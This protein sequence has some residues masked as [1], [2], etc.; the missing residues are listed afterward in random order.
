MSI[1]LYNSDI[2]RIHIILFAFVS[3]KLGNQNH[4]VTISRRLFLFI[5]Q[6]VCLFVCLFVSCRY[7]NPFN[8][9]VSFSGFCLLLQVQIVTLFRD[10][11][12]QWRCHE[13][14]ITTTLT[15]CW[16]QMGKQKQTSSQCFT[17]KTSYLHGSI[18]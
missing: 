8:K 9:S 17:Y 7:L 2:Q 12:F 6:L 1:Q 10:K 15:N 16:W 4:F 14:Y 13:C 3:S 11:Q 5:C 18:G